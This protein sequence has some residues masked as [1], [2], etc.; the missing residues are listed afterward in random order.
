MLIRNS[1]PTNK[2][3]IGHLSLSHTHPQQS[4][5]PPPLPLAHINCIRE[6]LDCVEE[7]VDTGVGAMHSHALIHT[8]NK[9]RRQSTNTFPKNSKKSPAI[10][11]TV[12]TILDC[13]GDTEASGHSPNPQDKTFTLHKILHSAAHTESGSPY[14]GPSRHH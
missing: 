6:E 14:H 9:L 5:A 2:S 11:S 1:K 8:I 13:L 3:S 10:L 12:L 7:R 4:L